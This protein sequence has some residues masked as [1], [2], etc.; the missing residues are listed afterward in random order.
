MHDFDDFFVGFAQ[1]EHQSR[2]GRHVRNTLFEVFQKIQRP[3]E[4]R[5]GT[6]RAIKPRYGFQIVIE[7]IRRFLLGYRQCHIHPATIIG[8]QRLE[9]HPGG[10]LADFPQ[11]ID[12]MLRPSI[13]Q[14][15]TI[16]RGDDNVLE[17]QVSYG[18]R[19]IVR[20]LRIKRLRSPVPHIAERAATCADVAH[21]HERGGTTRKAL[22]QIRTGRFF[23]HAVQ[24]MLAQQLL[25]PVD[26]GTDGHAH[27]DPVRLARQFICRNDLD[28][29]TRN[30]LRPA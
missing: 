18:N 27:P 7:H 25:D 6:R 19:Q 1:T 11:A 3:L 24:T 8:H 16:H 17:L 9:L 23:A 30:F 10:K 29:N 4:I 15:V 5:A 14:V 21:D 12:K 28:R 26:L 20:L 22:S 2:L 13:A